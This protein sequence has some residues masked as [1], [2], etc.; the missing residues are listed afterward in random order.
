MKRLEV[1]PSFYRA[2]PLPRAKTVAMGPSLRYNP[3]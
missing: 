3:F 2:E 1:K